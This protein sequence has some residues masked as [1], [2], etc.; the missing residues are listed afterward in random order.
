MSKDKVLPAL[1]ALCCTLLVTQAAFAQSAQDVAWSVSKASGEVWI[2]AAD[3]QPRSVSSA[4]K[5]QAGDSIRTGKA[6]RVVLTRGQERIVVSPNTALGIPTERKGDLATTITQQAGTILLNVEKRNVQH[7][8]VETPFLAAVVKGTQF[9]VT[10]RNGRAQVRVLQGQVQVADFKSGQMALVKPGQAA[11]SSIRGGLQLSGI[12]KLNAVEQGPPRQTSVRAL[13]VPSGGF[14]P[15][16][17]RSSQESRSRNTFSNQR[18]GDRAFARGPRQ[19]A[20]IKVHKGGV[21][22]GAPLGEVKLDFQKATDGLARSKSEANAAGYRNEDRPIGKRDSSVLNPDV[23]ASG[24]GGPNSR[25]N[26]GGGNAAT[27]GDPGRGNGNGN[28]GPGNGGGNVAGV[29]NGNG[30]GVAN[31]LADGLGDGV[32]NLLGKVK[33]KLKLK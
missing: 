24:L 33:G 13:P 12:G 7:F 22:I 8:E 18:G 10:V 17:A 15:P 21:R 4:A 9:R 20:G 6:G 31:G 25:S 19:D 28:G 3:G 27:G 30:N 16:V 14:K 32:G 29:N 26:G 2:T 1:A 11:Q 23:S 5:L